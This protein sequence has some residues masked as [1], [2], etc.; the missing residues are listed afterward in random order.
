VTT[1]LQFVEH[2]AGDAGVLIGGDG[3]AH[4]Q[5]RYRGTPWR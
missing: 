2:G 3:D 4:G 1:R 5:S